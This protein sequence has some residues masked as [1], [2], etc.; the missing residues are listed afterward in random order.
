[1]SQHKFASNVVEKLLQLSDSETRTMM[2]NEITGMRQYLYFCTSK[3]VFFTSKKVQILALRLRTMML[4][5]ITGIRMG[6]P[7]VL[8]LLEHEALS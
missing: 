3:Q 5:E 1:M 6:S 2:L 4:K 7:A 8:M